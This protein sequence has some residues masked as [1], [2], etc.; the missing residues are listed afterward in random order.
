MTI[1][2]VAQRKGGVGKTTI[3][4]NVAGELSRRNY[5]VALMDSDPQRSAC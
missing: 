3:A 4:V 1:I 5:D 2:T